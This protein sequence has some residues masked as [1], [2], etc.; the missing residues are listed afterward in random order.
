MVAVTGSMLRDLIVCERRVHHD[1][2][3]PV[4]GRDAVSDFVTMLWE[5]GRVHEERVL[6][7]L[8]GVVV[9]LRDL[10][11][12]VQGDA[13]I[14]AIGGDADWILGSRLELGDRLGRPDALHR[15]DGVWFA[16]DVKSGFALGD[17]GVSPKFDYLVQVGHYAALLGDMGLGAR[18]RAF[19]IDR[20]GGLVWYD[21]TVPRRRGRPSAAAEVEG[22]VAAAR[23]IRDG[24]LRTRAARSSV[25]GL[26][27]WRSTCE[28]ETLAADDL[29]LVAGLGR[30]L[31]ERIEPTAATVTAL[32]ALDVEGLRLSALGT[33]RLGRFRDRARLIRTPGAAP[34]AREPLGLSRHARELH[35]DLEADPLRGIVYLHGILVRERV[36]GEDREEFVHFF[37]D[38]DGGGEREAFRAAYRYLV[39]DPAAHIFYYSKFERTAYRDLQ[40]RYPDVC[41]PEDVEALFAPTRATDLYFDVVASR[42]EWPLSSY[43]IK[44]V[45][46]S[47]GF[48]WRDADASGAASIAWYDEWVR[49]RD[50]AVRNRIVEYNHDDCRATAVLLD[51]LIAMP[52][53]P[54][55]PWP[56]VASRPEPSVSAEPPAGAGGRFPS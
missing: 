7:Q 21:L 13:T 34:Y 39:A 46:K 33:D 18:D 30:S 2:H 50:P 6:A 55:P 35:F 19:V 54:S 43:G 37:A 51:A 49:N 31:R 32:A 11:H 12:E 10:P 53:S 52:V 27:H 41:D 42:T 17:D 16:G 25:C 48:A 9:D 38:G 26:C 20:D 28:R 1:L 44:P 22:L 3:A 23:G 47:L 24:D 56:P 14:A 36:G 4:E 15:I 5:G 45:A 8:E 40:R 29:T